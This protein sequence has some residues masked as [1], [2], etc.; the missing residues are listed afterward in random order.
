[1]L[2][3]RGGRST[4]NIGKTDETMPAF[5]IESLEQIKG[6]GRGGG[7][8]GNLGYA[9]RLRVPVIENTARWVMSFI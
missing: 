6:I 4:G 8:Q 5:E 2:V 7:K 9:D 3:E 1:M